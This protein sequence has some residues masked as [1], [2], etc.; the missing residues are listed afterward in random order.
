MKTSNIIISV[1][2]LLLIIVVTMFIAIISISHDEDKG[3]GDHDFI[4]ITSLNGS[5][6]ISGDLIKFDFHAITLSN[7][8]ISL[9]HYSKGKN[10][11]LAN[12]R[13][14]KQL[15]A[16][17]FLKPNNTYVIYEQSKN[18][19]LDDIVRLLALK[20]IPIGIARTQPSSFVNNKIDTSL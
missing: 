4:S 15:T 19:Y 13:T 14:A 8:G 12:Y 6:N 11:L 1:I 16:S 18:R 7:N 2:D 17:K 3:L 9:S 5:D 20:G 10:T